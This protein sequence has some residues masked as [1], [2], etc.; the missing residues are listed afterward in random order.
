MLALVAI[1]TASFVTCDKF[2]EVTTPV[3]ERAETASVTNV[4]AQEYDS[5]LGDFY[6]Y[7]SKF[8]KDT[9]LY[10]MMPCKA[11]KNDD[12]N[13][14]ISKPKY[15]DF[16]FVF[17]KT[18]KICSPNSKAAAI[19]TRIKPESSVLNFTEIKVANITREDF[20]KVYNNMDI[21]G[22]IDIFS[23]SKKATTD[24]QTI[25][26]NMIL[27]VKTQSNEYGLILVKSTSTTSVEVDACHAML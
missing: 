13:G 5:Q 20:Y 4:Q 18:N 22:L 14:V 19:I 25:A 7:S 17:D 12:T 8:S 6:A 26:K 16:I 2:S 27:A 23:K 21:K 9:P 1:C 3:I 15:I 10:I 24:Y 11:N